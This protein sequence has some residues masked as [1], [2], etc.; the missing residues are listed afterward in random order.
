MVTKQPIRKETRSYKGVTLT[1]K[2]ITE[3]DCGIVKQGPSTVWASY[4]GHVGGRGFGPMVSEIAAVRK[5]R[6]LAIKKKA[7]LKKIYAVK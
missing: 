5:L 6:E 1:L 3:S 2:P 7:I 4:Q